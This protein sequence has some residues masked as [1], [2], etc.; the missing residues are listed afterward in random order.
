MNKKAYLAP[1]ME[2]T[3][4]ETVEMIATSGNIVNVSNEVTED[5]ARMSNEHRGS[6]GDLWN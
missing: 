4:I 3:N 5:D 1:T 6:W 2:A